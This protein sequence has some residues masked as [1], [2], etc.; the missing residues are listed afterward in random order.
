[1]KATSIISLFGILKHCGL[2]ASQIIETSSGPVRGHAAT[3][4]PN[5][6]AYLGIRYAEPPVGSLRFMPP[7]RYHGSELIDGGSVV[8][9]L[10]SS[11]IEDKMLRYC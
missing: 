10:P 8:S 9:W 11:E 5:V 7:K 1:M 2:G 6:V 4:R 3:I